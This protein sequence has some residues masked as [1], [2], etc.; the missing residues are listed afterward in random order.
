[1][2]I[3]MSLNCFYETLSLQYFSFSLAGG[4]DQFLIFFVPT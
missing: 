1:M 3:E 2:M 4:D